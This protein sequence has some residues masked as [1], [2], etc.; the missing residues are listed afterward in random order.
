MVDGQKGGIPVSVR[1]NTA[2]C[3]IAGT[4]VTGI[5]GIAFEE[6]VSM[7]FA[8][9]RMAAAMLLVTGLFLFLAERIRNPRRTEADMTILDGI[10]IGFVQGV[11]LIPGISRSG[12][13]IAAGMMLKMSGEAAAR[14]SFL[15]SVPA[16]AGAMLLEF[17]KYSG[18]I[19]RADILVYGAGTAAAAAVGFFTLNLL[20]FMIK[21]RKLSIFA[22]YCWFVG[23]AALMI[24]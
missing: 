12:S 14:F 3:I 4:V 20:F 6:T 7:L 16:I 15:L 10:L 21:E 23:I 1:R 13:T 9:A 8:S 17:M 5:I 2:L 19:P 11:A 24:L 22:Y 18:S